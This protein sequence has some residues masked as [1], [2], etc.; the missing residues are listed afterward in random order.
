MGRVNIETQITDLIDSHKKET[1]ETPYF[2]FMGDSKYNELLESLMG[3]M[4]TISIDRYRDMKVICN[5]YITPEYLAVGN[6]EAMTKILERI[7]D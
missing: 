4:P 2:L 5:K 6:K 1:G 7:S 3:D